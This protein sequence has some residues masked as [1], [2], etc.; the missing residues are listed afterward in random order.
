VLMTCL[1]ACSAPSGTPVAQAVAATP[2]PPT[3]ASAPT[4]S[5]ADAGLAIAIARESV[6]R[7]VRAQTLHVQQLLRDQERAREAAI[8]AQAN[9]NQRC[10]AGQ[11]MRRVANG[12]EQAGVC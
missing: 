12:W 5:A 11:K 9:G 7:D 3:P 1:G 2:A 8:R 4:T 10:I 6:D